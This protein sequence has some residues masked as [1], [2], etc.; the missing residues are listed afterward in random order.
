MASHPPSQHTFHATPLPCGVKM[1]D[2]ASRR[3][4]PV[5]PPL[6]LFAMLVTSPM[7]S[8]N[9]AIM[10]FLRG[11][12]VS[13]CTKRPAKREDSKPVTRNTA[14]PE[15]PLSAAPRECRLPHVDAA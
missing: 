13:G 6:F 8:P 12:A 15:I 10:R 9:P 14:R 1:S 3:C 5:L 11:A 2:H 7:G 4:P